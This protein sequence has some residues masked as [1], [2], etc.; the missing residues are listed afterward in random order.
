MYTFADLYL[1][2]DL[3]QIFKEMEVVRGG[4]PPPLPDNFGRTKLTP[5]NH[6]SLERKFI[7]ESDSFSIS[8]KYFDFAILSAICEKFNCQNLG[9]FREFEKHVIYHFKAR[10]L[11]I[12]M[13]YIICFEKFFEF[14]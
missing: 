10:G 4:R 3:L 5:T 1:Y 14:L 8:R 7:G 13:I 11:E 6:T 9:H 12:N 2:L